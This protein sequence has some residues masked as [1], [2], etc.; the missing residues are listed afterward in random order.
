M[1]DFDTVMDCDMKS[2][3]FSW[4]KNGKLNASGKNSGVP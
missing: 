1:Q 4:F 3:R 2:G